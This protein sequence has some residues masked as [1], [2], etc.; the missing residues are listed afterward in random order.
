VRQGV[1]QGEPEAQEPQRACV[2]RGRFRALSQVKGSE[3]RGAARTRARRRCASA[4]CAVRGKL[5]GGSQKRE[6]RAN[7]GGRNAMF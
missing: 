1:Q 5:C 7:A 4:A 6:R 3:T 2:W